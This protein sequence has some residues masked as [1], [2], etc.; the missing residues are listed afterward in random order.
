MAGLLGAQSLDWSLTPQ[1]ARE[2]SL[3]TGK[4]LLVCWL[5]G[6]QA[7]AFAQD[8]DR[9]FAAWPQWTKQLASQVIPVKL[10]SWENPSRDG[11]PVLPDGG[12][13]C[14]LGLGRPKAEAWLATWAAV[15]GILEFSRA[16]AASAALPLTDPY[17]LDAQEFDAAERTLVRQDNGPLWLETAGAATRLWK[18]E[19][20]QGSVLVLRDTASALKA[21]FP[22]EGGWSFLYNPVDQRWTPWNAVEVKRR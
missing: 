3:A 15:P 22:L 17:T 20:P 2:A 6:P 7:T 18:E 11:L 4:P 9:L 10:R 8:A 13:S 12:K 5:A 14:L 19:G 1:A 16:L 21:A